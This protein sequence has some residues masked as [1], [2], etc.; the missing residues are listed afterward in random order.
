[1]LVGY[2]SGDVWAPQIDGA[3]ALAVETRHLIDCITNNKKPIAD[4]EAGLRVVRMLEAATE[5]MR[6]GGRIV[7]LAKSGVSA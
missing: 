7:E 3:E 6:N 2:R 5:S 4:G 1:M